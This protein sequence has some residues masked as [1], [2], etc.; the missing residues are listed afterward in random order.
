MV[1]KRTW[2]YQTTVYQRGVIEKADID[3]ARR[4]SLKMGWLYYIIAE[5]VITQ[6]RSQLFNFTSEKI[7]NKITDNTGLRCRRKHIDK[8]LQML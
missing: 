6:K 5:V 3:K 4:V 2:N 7:L 1:R 8:N